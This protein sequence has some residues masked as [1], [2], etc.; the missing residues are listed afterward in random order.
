MSVVDL[1]CRLKTGAS[2][3]EIKKAIKDASETKMK[4]VLGYTEDAVVS[5]GEL[6]LLVIFCTNSN[7]T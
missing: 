1:T 2:M 6:I 3:D 4:G 7:G 5:S